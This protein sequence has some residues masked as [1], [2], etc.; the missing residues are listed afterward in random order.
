MNNIRD[1]ILSTNS[2]TKL[3]INTSLFNIF[4]MAHNFLFFILLWGK[5]KEKKQSSEKTN[6]TKIQCTCIVNTVLLWPFLKDILFTIKQLKQHILILH[7]YYILNIDIWGY[8]QNG[9]PWDQKLSLGSNCNSCLPD[10]NLHCEFSQSKCPVDR[11]WLHKSSF[12]D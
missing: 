12:I 11:L 2:Y 9:E 5:K 4:E 3:Q 10:C 7:V 6:L 8:K 1:R